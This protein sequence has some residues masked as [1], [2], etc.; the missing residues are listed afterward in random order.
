MKSV[1]GEHAS[2]CNACFTGGYPVKFP[3]LG[4]EDEPQMGLFEKEIEIK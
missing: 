4:Q 1:G 2:F 3:R